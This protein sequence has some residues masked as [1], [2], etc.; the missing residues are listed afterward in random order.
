MNEIVI[1]LYDQTA[2][3]TLEAMRYETGRKYDLYV[4]EDIS[5]YEGVVLDIVRSDGV[6]VIGRCEAELD[7]HL[8]HVLLPVNALKEVCNM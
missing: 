5:G 7:E 4:T 8:V 3:L 2:Q 6:H 1:S